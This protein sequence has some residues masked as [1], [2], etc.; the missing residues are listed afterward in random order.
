MQRPSN[1]HSLY[2][3]ASR[4]WGR[5]PSLQKRTFWFAV[6]SMMLVHFY[7]FTNKLLNHDELY[8]LI[9][10]NEMTSSG[11]W[12]LRF[13]SALSSSV[14]MPWVL[15]AL[16]TLFFALTCCLLVSLFR[17]RRT[18]SVAMLCLSMAT[19]PSCAATLTYLFQADALFISLFLS[20]SAVWLTRRIRWGGIPSALCICVSVGIYQ[21]YYPF[22]ASLFV[23]T[24]L[25]D[26]FDAKASF[27]AILRRG[28]RYVA[29]LTA[30]LLFYFVAL[31]ICLSV[32]H[33]A[34][35]DYQG[36]SQ[37]GKAS[38]GQF[39]DAVLQAY[40]QYFRY[41]F[42]NC[43]QFHYQIS[44]PIAWLGALS[45]GAAIVLIVLHRRLYRSPLLLML[46]C[47]LIGLIPLAG[48]LIYVM[49]PNGVVHSLM[50]YP[51]V[52]SPILLAVL[53]ERLSSFEC[54]RLGRLLCI[55]LGIVM[56][57]VCSF[58]IYNDYLLV[59]Q[60]YMRQQLATEQA[61]S[62]A[63][64]LTARIETADGY[65]YETPL[66]LVGTPDEGVLYD[67]LDRYA[68]LRHLTGMSSGDA[69][70]RAYSFDHLL[71]DYIGLPNPQLS[72]VAKDDFLA[73]HD[74]AVSAMPLYPAA[75]SI[76]IVDGVLVVRFSAP[77]I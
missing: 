72:G 24:L 42:E 38:D 30:G 76:S 52:L 8:S 21:A 15:G 46:V 65:T 32:T 77:S 17:L 5:V 61:I 48:N 49:A 35:S 31:R 70:V 34:L 25:L 28:L 19:F 14:S 7:M 27:S 66:A 67:P 29:V 11:R 60:G 36:I 12:A 55:S 6:G 13:F 59:N 9:S 20:V 74:A 18:L 53:S 56:L 4:L 68:G 54:G 41:F 64:R 69:L 51:L 26:A 50:M 43:R 33:T 3:S 58:W 2:D 44:I 47:A 75:G 37:M 10:R 71:A 45:G 39:V 40:R 73:H 63:N 22:A 23:L 57:G 16:C 1:V 62:Y